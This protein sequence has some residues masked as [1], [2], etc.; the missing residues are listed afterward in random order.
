MPLTYTG[1]GLTIQVPFR[2]PGLAPAA[3]NAT[4]D[5]VVQHG[6]V[7]LRLA[8]PTVGGPSW[9]AEPGRFLLRTGRRGGRFLVEHGGVTLDRNPAGEDRVLATAFVTIVLAAALVQRGSLVLH[10]NAAEL[11]RGAVVIAGGSG[12]GKSTTLAALLAARC[13]MLTDDVT[14]LRIGDHGRVEVVPG[15]GEVRLTP[16]ASTRLGLVLPPDL[17]APWGREKA[18]LPA[19]AQLATEPTPLDRIYLLEASPEPDFEV[20]QLTGAQKLE[21]LL[22][23]LYGPLFAAEHPGL[24]PICAAVLE[25]VD[26]FRIRRPAEAWSIDEVRSVLL[27]GAAR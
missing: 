11:D 3:D 23:S 10:A 14:V 17:L 4:A 5:L 8:A 7:P 2:C 25:Q 26:L 6:R 20:T 15:V 12:S 13:K 22:A 1:Y 24:F 9:E 27:D 18:V 21:G 16:A 19:R